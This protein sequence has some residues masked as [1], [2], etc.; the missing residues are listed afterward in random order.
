MLEVSAESIMQG[1]KSFLDQAGRALADGDKVAAV[2][3]LTDVLNAVQ[4]L[5]DV[6]EL[7]EQCKHTTT[8]KETL[9]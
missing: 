6:L 5:N 9:P 2:D 1:I 8:P 7:P 3:S 4:T